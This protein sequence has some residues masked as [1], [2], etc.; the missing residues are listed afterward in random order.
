MHRVTTA[1]G[2]QITLPDH[3]EVVEDTTFRRRR[4]GGAWAREAA[5]APDAESA[6]EADVLV[7]ALEEQ[8]MTVLDDFE[9]TQRMRRRGPAE[10]EMEAGE[11][12]PSRVRAVLPA[13][14]DALLLIE[15]D[16]VYRWEQGTREGR[17]LRRRGPDA[18]AEPAATLVT[19]EVV[20]GEP[21]AAEPGTVRRRD[22]GDAVE[23]FFL[24]RARAWV[25]RFVAGKAV[26]G[27]IRLLERKVRSGLVVIGAVDPAGW[28]P[29]DTLAGVALPADRPARILLFVHGTF[30]STVGSFGALASQPQGRSFLE[31]ALSHYDL[32]LGYDHRTL[33]ESP[34]ENAVALLA[35]LEAASWPR[36]PR[37]NAVCFSRGGLVYRSLVEQVLPGAPWRPVLERSIFVGCTSSGTLLAEPDKWKDLLDLYT[38]LAVG[39]TRLLGRIP[40]VA[41]AARVLREAVKSLGIFA[42]YLAQTA[43]TERRAP[44]LAAMEPDGEFVRELNRTQSGQPTAHTTTYYAVTSSF[45]PGAGPGPEELPKRFVRWLADGA[46]DRLMGEPNDLVV[47]VASMTAFDLDD[48]DWIDQSL[49]FGDNATIYHTVYFHQPAVQERIHRWLEADTPALRTSTGA[50]ERALATDV[51][52][53]EVTTTSAE[54]GRRLERSP[55]PFRYM[56]INDSRGTGPTR[57]FAMKTE[58]VVETLSRGAE[59]ADGAEFADVPDIAHTFDFGVL[60]EAE[61]VPASRIRSARGSEQPVVVTSDGGEPVGVLE[62]PPRPLSAAELR[63]N[64]A[65]TG[66]AAPALGSSEG[67]RE[68]PPAAEVECELYAEMPE[69]VRVGETA[70]LLVELSREAIERALGPA[71]AVGGFRAD[72]ARGIHVDVVA[73]DRC[74]VVGEARETLPPPSLGFPH[75]LIFDIEALEEGPG[76]VWVLARQERT[77]LV[78]LVLSPT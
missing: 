21:P 40:Q 78:T 72:K 46:V 47:H 54:L 56:I 17:P 70:P 77:A 43:I 6:A 49:P 61:V 42:K 20:L 7:A 51:E 8:E 27:L 39:A 45:E 63:E 11:E 23:G 62:P 38:N 65:A 26:S 41:F 57:R 24:G 29:R 1:R 36:P 14:E 58:D 5:L 12:E 4:R 64:A 19:F 53:V 74:R 71:A 32:V 31:W 60:Q 16:G 28:T 68:E 44:G 67:R 55:R 73:R 50:A 25:F 76:E 30:S 35:A 13:N 2:L 66:A 48:A 18:P 59:G 75:R 52:V 69:E 22:L 10:F 37:I 9:I 33:S 34:A 3:L 15:E